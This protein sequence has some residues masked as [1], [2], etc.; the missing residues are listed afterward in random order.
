MPT[1]IFREE[2][3]RLVAAGA[4]L[5]DVLDAVEYRQEHIDGAQSLPL[6][7]LTR[8][9]AERDLSRDRP[10]VVYCNDWL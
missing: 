7:Q 2:V 8:Q 10:V 4:Q 3:Q 1:D 9:R 6:D 5:V